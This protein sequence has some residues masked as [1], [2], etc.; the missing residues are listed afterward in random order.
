MRHQKK[1]IVFAFGA[2]AMLA[3][4]AC[5]ALSGGMPALPGMPNIA[6][7]ETQDAVVNAATPASPMSGN[8]KASFDSGEVVFHISRDG[9]RIYAAD[10]SLQGWHCGGTTMSTSMQVQSPDW[11]V[12]GDQFSMTIDL[13]PPHVEELT[14]DGAYDASTQTWLGK[15]D[16]DEY[17]THCGGKWQ[18]SKLP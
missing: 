8:W 12:D 15:W 11:T 1:Q 4:M 2:L 9:T 17:G 14:F 6:A 16:G 18:A 13:N 5:A 3:T 7:T 10:V